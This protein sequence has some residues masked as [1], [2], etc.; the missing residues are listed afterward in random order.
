M[1]ELKHECLC[2]RSMDY[3]DNDKLITLYAFGNGK[4]TANCRGVKKPKAKLRYAA[5]ILCFGT[6]Y[7]TGRN[8]F[9]T[10][11]GC[12][13]IDSFYGLWGDIDK[14]YPALSAIEML[15]K[16]G[17][18]SEISDNLAASTLLFLKSLCY[19]KVVNIPLFYLKYLYDS[20][21]LIGYKISGD[22]CA[23]CG[24]SNGRRAYFSSSNG[25]VVYECCNGYGSIYL[26]GTQVYILSDLNNNSSNELRSRNVSN[27][28]NISDNIS[29]L[30][31]DANIATNENTYD[32]DNYA[33]SNSDAEISSE[34]DV[35]SH[36]IILLISILSGY[37]E[38]IIEKKLKAVKEY[39]DFLKI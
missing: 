39:I 22:I 3:K 7:L 34:S 26:T 18:D 17:G 21:A 30:R 13:Q 15:D 19:E 20:L 32:M 10:V 4:I 5:S 27:A 29:V 12:D 33:K 16:F 35:M 8:G 24:N 38:Y 9:Y 1:N 2:I 11:T 23:C 31:V 14:Y 6:Y 37:I 25:G 28:T 36:D